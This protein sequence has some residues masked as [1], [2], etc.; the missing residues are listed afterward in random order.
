VA[1]LSGDDA[2]RARNEIYARNGYIFTTEK[3]RALARMLGSEYRAVTAD[4]DAVSNAFNQYESANVEVLKKIERGGGAANPQPYTPA[5][6]Y[7]PPAPAAGMWLFADSS[8]RRLSRAELTGLNAAQLWRAR[9]EIY[10]R[11]GSIF[12]K[13]EGKALARSLGA[14][15][16]PRTASAD[17]VEA[18]FNKVEEANVKLIKSLE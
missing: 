1:G 2:W 13:P 17:A 3:G 6:P 12:S 16:T 14:A 11:H 10:A 4:Q 7:T 15:Y 5:Q 8:T 18:S 9:N